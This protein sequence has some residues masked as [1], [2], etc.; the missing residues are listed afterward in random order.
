[1][2]SFTYEHVVH[3]PATVIAALEQALDR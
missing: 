3:R 1:M 2:L